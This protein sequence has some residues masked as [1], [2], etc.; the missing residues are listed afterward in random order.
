MPSFFCNSKKL[1]SHKNLCENKDFCKVIM[2]SEDTKILEFIQYQKYYKAPFI[3]YANLECIIEE[4]VGCKNN[5]ENVSTTKVSEHI[6]SG[7]PI[8]TISS[9]R[10]K[11]NKHE[12]YRDKDC[13]K[14]FCKFLRNL[15]MK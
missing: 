10:S 15:A 1:E 9:F 11:E 12:V 6:P 3:V 8:Y 13:M 5:P 14:K 7:F 2:P 4:I